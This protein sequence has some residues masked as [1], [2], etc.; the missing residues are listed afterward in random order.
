MQTGRH[1]RARLSALVLG[2]FG[3][4]LLLGIL[5]LILPLST[6]ERDTAVVQAAQSDGFILPHPM[7]LSDVP[8]VVLERGGLLLDPGEAAR[9]VSKVILD[10]PQFHVDLGREPTLFGG[11]L[12]NQVAGPELLHPLAGL[13][14]N[15]GY[16]HLSIR[17]GDLKVTW[18]GGQTLRLG[19]I[20]ADIN[21]RRKPTISGSGEATFNGQRVMFDGSIGV[22][23]EGGKGATGRPLKGSLKAPMMSVNFDG[24]VD[25]GETPRLIGG[26]D[27]AATD[28][29]AVSRWLG[30][31]MPGGG[32][33]SDLAV[34]GQFSWERGTATV[35]KASVALDKTSIGTGVVSYSYKSGR[36]ALDAA[37]A[38]SVLDVTLPVLSMIP[39]ANRGEGLLAWSHLRPAMPGLHAFDADLRF[40]ASKV[41][42]GDLQLGRGAAS[43]SV[44]GGKLNADVAELMVGSD[45]L[46]LQVGVDMTVAEPRYSVRGRADFVDVGPMSHRLFGATVLSGK[47]SA[48]VDVKGG[49]AS[50]G[51]ILDH[52]TGKVGLVGATGLRSVFDPRQLKV[53]AT[54]NKDGRQLAGDALM[55]SALLA[56]DALDIK[57]TVNGPAWSIDQGAVRAGATAIGLDGA[58]D[59][60]KRTLDL[61]VL[62]QAAAGGKK[63]SKSGG[64]D[65]HAVTISGAWD[66]PKLTT[67]DRLSPPP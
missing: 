67:L 6:G 38:F 40:S 28:I 21:L 63:G 4:L 66:A 36:P 54:G 27:L 65:G 35:D 50:L 13:I 22:L 53:I 23:G 29:S 12:P 34:K 26:L 30:L 17:N 32:L 2:V 10:R 3:C 20:S 60:G 52:A 48:Q 46:N 44:K 18:A 25:A 49:G 45:R 61:R 5:P 14:A 59:L 39:E 33:F 8:A 24:V 16:D 55:A 43:F 47:A 11:R 62:S 64:A 57:V 7:R 19:D 58:V 9:G 51:H 37:L 15:L 1:L 31:G 56:I 41:V 42:A